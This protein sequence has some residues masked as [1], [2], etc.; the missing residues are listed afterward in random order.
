MRLG[1]HC[2]RGGCAA[3]EWSNGER[4]SVASG[5]SPRRLALPGRDALAVFGGI[6]AMEL[7]SCVTLF[8]GVAPKEPLLRDALQAYFAGEPDPPTQRA[9]RD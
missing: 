3:L 4:P 2:R 9:L 6:G 1:A 7:R 5:S 8:A